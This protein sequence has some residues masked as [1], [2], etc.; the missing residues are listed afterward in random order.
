MLPNVGSCHR[1][2]C[3]SHCKGHAEFE[4]G[5]RYAEHEGLEAVSKQQ[6]QVSSNKLVEKLKLLASHS[7]LAQ[8][9]TLGPRV[10]V[11]ARWAWIAVPLPARPCA[12]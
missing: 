12:A 2:S 6:A 10:M 7:S 8:Q 11:R 9:S 5:R 4:E 1:V 3:H